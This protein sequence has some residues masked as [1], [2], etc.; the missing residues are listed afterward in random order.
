M[1]CV[2]GPPHT[3]W[4]GLDWIGWD[5][6]DIRGTVFETAPKKKK[7]K[8][9]TDRYTHTKTDKTLSDTRRYEAISQA[10]SPEGTIYLLITGTSNRN[11][12]PKV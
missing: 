1:L 12:L 6:M 7:E 3:L 9:Q 11:N 10:Q 8:I 2:K 4:D 5:G